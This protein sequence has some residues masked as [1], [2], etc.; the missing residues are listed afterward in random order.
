VYAYSSCG[1]GMAI[2]C[3][4]IDLEGLKGAGKEKIIE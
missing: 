3:A 2:Q 1:R 4:V